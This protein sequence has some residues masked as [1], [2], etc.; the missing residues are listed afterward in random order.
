MRVLPAHHVKR[1]RTFTAY[2]SVSAGLLFAIGCSLPSV[3]IFKDEEPVE[4]IWALLFGWFHLFPLTSSRLRENIGQD[5][6]QN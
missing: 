4:G 1:L 2:C 6:G 3:G 5:F